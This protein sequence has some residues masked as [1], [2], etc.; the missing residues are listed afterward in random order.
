MEQIEVKQGDPGL[1]NIVSRENEATKNR[2]QTI[3]V[4]DKMTKI[5]DEKHLL[6]SYQGERWEQVNKSEKLS[7]DYYQVT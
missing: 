3:V 7:K 2:S 4:N 6:I 1:N 5:D